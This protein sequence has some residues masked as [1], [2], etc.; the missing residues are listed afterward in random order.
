MIGD[1]TLERLQADVLA[2]L[3]VVPSLEA[4]NLLEEDDGDMEAKIMRSLG[5]MTGGSTGRGGCVAVVMLPEVTDAESNQPGPPMTFQIQVQVIEQPV[6]N[7]GAQGTR[8][9]SSKAA[10]RILNALHLQ[11]MGS[12]LIYAGDKAITP[13]DVKPGFLSHIVTLTGRVRSLAAPA[14][15]QAL[16]V[17][18]VVEDVEIT[19]GTAEAV[20]YYTVDGSFPTPASGLL[21]D[22]PFPAPAVGTTVRA[23]AYVPTQNPSDL[24]EF[25]ITE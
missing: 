11:A 4:L 5:A 7:R 14:K 13:V 19:C 9:R 2:I 25:T 18:L 20:I 12:T 15:P 16:S 1:D 23:V 3:K 22:V 6:I 10:L 21:Y 17:A 8:I 24:L